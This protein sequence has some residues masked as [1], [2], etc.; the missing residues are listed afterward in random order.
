MC[1]L[2][3]T[4]NCCKRK[5]R[6]LSNPKSCFLGQNSLPT[7]CT[8][9]IEINA[10]ICNFREFGGR[11][12]LC[13]V[14]YIYIY[15]CCKRQIKALLHHPLIYPSVPRL[16]CLFLILLCSWN[17]NY[18]IRGRGVGGRLWFI[19][20]KK[21]NNKIM[22]WHLNNIFMSSYAEQALFYRLTINWTGGLYHLKP[23]NPLHRPHH[24][25]PRTN[26]NSWSLT[27]HIRHTRNL[28]DCFVKSLKTSNNKKDPDRKRES[29]NDDNFQSTRT[30]KLP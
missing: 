21:N 27:K 9:S 22:I 15:D 16:Q 30:G 17:L 29:Q 1:P 11:V 24:Q 19:Q 2:G 20:N 12:F 25:S 7:T 10:N 13:A 28:A 6:Y 5:K 18:R 8:K 26:L 3:W 14:M 4:R 23:Q